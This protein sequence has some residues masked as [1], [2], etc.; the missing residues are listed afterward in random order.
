MGKAGQKHETCFDQDREITAGSNNAVRSCERQATDPPLHEHL[1]ELKC[2]LPPVI[3]PHNNYWIWGW[4]RR[5]VEHPVFIIMGGDL[6][7]HTGLVAEIAPAATIRCRYCIP[8]EN[9]LPIFVGRGFRNSFEE[10][11]NSVKSFI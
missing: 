8:Y 3:L 10:S 2:D 6:Q 11:W 9:N 5:D 1:R 4:E 7:E